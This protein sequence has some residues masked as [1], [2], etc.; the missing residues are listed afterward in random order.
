MSESVKALQPLRRT[1][2]TTPAARRS[3]GDGEE[4]QPGFKGDVSQSPLYVTDDHLLLRRDEIDAAVIIEP[5]LDL[6][7]G[8]YATEAAIGDVW[9]GAEARSD[10]P[11]EYIGTVEYGCSYLDE[12]A[13]IRD[14]L[15]GVMVVDAHLLA[16]GIR[17]VHPNMLTVSAEP[18]PQANAG[19]SS[20]RLWSYP[21][22]FRRGGKLVG[23]LM[24]LRLGAHVFPEY[25]LCGEPIT[26]AEAVR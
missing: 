13:F 5:N 12:V 4:W 15:G 2:P 16:F 8:R 1:L 19:P 24:P 22:A 25:D 7:V 20:P 6:Y 10:V 23:L 26:L 11:A 14:A 17:A 21:L 9:R 18:E 3:D